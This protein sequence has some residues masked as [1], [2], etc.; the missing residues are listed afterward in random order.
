[1]SLTI[2]DT[3]AYTISAESLYAAAMTAVTNLEGKLESQDADAGTIVVK[4]HKTILG[5]VLG[6]RTHFE[7]TIRPNDEGSELDVMGYPLDAVGRKLQFG[8]RKGVAQTVLSWIH[9]HIDHNLK[10]ANSSN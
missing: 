9:A 7:L 4:F 5:K 3:K 1:M 2:N 6:D 10:S 8:G